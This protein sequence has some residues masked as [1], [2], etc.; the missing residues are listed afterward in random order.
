M[1]LTTVIVDGTTR[2]ARLEQDDLVLLPAPDVGALLRHD[3][4]QSLAAQPSGPRIPA[5]GT[6]LGL[7]FPEPNKIICVGLNYLSHIHEMGRDVPKHPT[8]FAKFSGALLAPHASIAVPPVSDQLDW[9]AELVV[10]VGRTARYVSAKKAL[11][12]IAGYTVGNDITVR[13]YQHRTR[14]FLSGKTFEATTPIG[15]VLVTPDELPEGGLGLGLTCRVDGEIRQSSNTVDLLFGPEDLIAY[16]SEIVTLLPG[17]L[18]MT[19]TPGGVG[20]GRDPKLWLRP[21]QLLTTEIEGIGTLRNHITKAE[22][23]P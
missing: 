20:A 3:N 4:W 6:E 5:A 11:E 21:G 7:L 12:H 23:R 19:G 10:V 13:D 9:E 15:P 22:A 2:A 16:V 8:L 14:E 17:D 1:R 18:I